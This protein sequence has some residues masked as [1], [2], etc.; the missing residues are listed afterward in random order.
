MKVYLTLPVMN[1]MD[2]RFDTIPSE[3]FTTRKAAESYGKKLVAYR[4][5]DGCPIWETYEV[6]SYDVKT[7]VPR[8]VTY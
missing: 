5:E 1:K 6:I 3:T 2:Y 7:T 4:D 8:K